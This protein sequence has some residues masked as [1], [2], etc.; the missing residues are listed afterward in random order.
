[1]MKNQI[2]SEATWRYI[3]ELK[4][5]DCFDSFWDELHNTIVAE[6]ANNDLCNLHEA[7]EDIRF[8]I[9][10]EFE[11][12]EDMLPEPKCPAEVIVD[13]SLNV[14]EFNFLWPEDGV[15]RI[16]DY[17]AKDVCKDGIMNLYFLKRN[18]I[19]RIIIPDDILEIDVFSFDSCE[20]SPIIEV[21]SDIDICDIYGIYKIFQTPLNII[22]R[23]KRDMSEEDRNNIRVSILRYYPSFN[24]D[25]MDVD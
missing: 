15:V 11:D 4:P 16:P 6:Y 21:N 13:E 24:V 9:Q 8:N 23:C 10:E 20:P 12:I 18:D 14:D 19:T 25:F 2:L 3:T 7:I 22:L 1:M 5:Y 17:L